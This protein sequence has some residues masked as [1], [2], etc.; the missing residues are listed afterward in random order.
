MSTVCECL[1][2]LA[3][4]SNGLLYTI[5]KRLFL[6]SLRSKRPDPVEL[7][8]AVVERASRSVLDE[9]DAEDSTP[10]D[11]DSVPEGQRRTS[12]IMSCPD[13]HGDGGVSVERRYE[14][15]L[16]FLRAPLT[17]AE[18][19]LAEA[20]SKGKANAQQVRVNSLRRKYARSLAVLTALHESPQPNEA[21]SHACSRIW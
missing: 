2:V 9:W 6:D 7:T 15:F 14:A 21:Q 11:S 18:A 10:S 12:L 16:E 20:V 3:I 19:S 4:P 5:A 8:A 1:P 17:R 13:G